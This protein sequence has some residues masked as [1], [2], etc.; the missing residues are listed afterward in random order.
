MRMENPLQSVC[1]GF[2]GKT[3]GLYPKLIGDRKL[4]RIIIYLNKSFTFHI[5]VKF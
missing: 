1:E 4:E 3:F 5:I 2:K